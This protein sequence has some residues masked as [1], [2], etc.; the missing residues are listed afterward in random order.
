MGDIMAMVN[1]LRKNMDED[2]TAPGNIFKRLENL[3]T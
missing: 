1:E 3:E 2:K